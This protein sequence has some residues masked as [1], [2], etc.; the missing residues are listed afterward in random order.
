M[1]MI[2]EREQRREKN[3]DVMKRLA[4]KKPAKPLKDPAIA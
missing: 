3:L 4:E 2:F 1:Q